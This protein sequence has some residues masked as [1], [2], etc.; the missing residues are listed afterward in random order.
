[1]SH[2]HLVSDGEETAPSPRRRHVIRRWAGGV[3][4]LIDYWECSPG[5]YDYRLLDASEHEVGRCR[6]EGGVKAPLRS[7]RRLL[8]RLHRAG[9]LRASYDRR[10]PYLVSEEVPACS[11]P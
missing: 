6:K 4:F 5:R 3:L 1:V 2:L 7:G 8:E 9:G 10:P 11:E